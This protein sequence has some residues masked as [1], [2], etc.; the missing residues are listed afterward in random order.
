MAGGSAEIGFGFLSAQC[1]ID[2]SRKSVSGIR[3]CGDVAGAIRVILP[4]K[5]AGQPQ[6]FKVSS[7][8]YIE[9]ALFV[10]AVLRDCDG[11]QHANNGYNDQ[12]LDYC[13]S[14]LAR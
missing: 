11:S 7:R 6:D 1:H 2:S 5:I 12:Q 14:V 10:L 8:V 13:K 4:I 3:D 9:C